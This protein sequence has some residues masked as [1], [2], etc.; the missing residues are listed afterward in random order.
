MLSCFYKMRSRLSFVADIFLRRGQQNSYDTNC[1][2]AALQLLR[3]DLRDGGT[4]EDLSL[5]CIFLNQKSD[6]SAE[7]EILYCIYFTILFVI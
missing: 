6:H 1:C 2:C 7:I 3:S 5:L 4:Q